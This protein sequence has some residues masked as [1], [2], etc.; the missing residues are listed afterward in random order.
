MMNHSEDNDFLIF[1][2]DTLW[3]KEYFDE[4]IKM[5]EFYFSKNRKYFIISKKI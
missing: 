3:Q 4:I 2:P 1:N 5:E